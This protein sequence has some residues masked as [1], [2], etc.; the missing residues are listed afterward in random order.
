MSH[1]EKVGF[2][3]L[4]GG[5]MSS[6]VWTDITAKISLPLITPEY[7]LPENTEYARKMATISD[8]SDYIIGLIEESKFE[9]AILV[10]HSGAGVIAA[11]VAKIIPQRI[12]HIVYIA[13]S[14]PESGKSAVDSLPLPLRLLNKA[15]INSQVKR[16]FTPA[17]KSEKI[18]RKKFC[19]TCSEESIKYVLKQNLLSE[20]LCLAFEKSNWDG[21]PGVKQ[22]Y[23]ILTKDETISVSG[24]KKMMDHLSISSFLEIESGHMVML[25][26]PEELAK[27]LNSIIG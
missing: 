27:V 24:Q 18:I 15:A 5:G 19:N 6:W 23:I 12:L 4:A 8:C 16:D 14:I 11:N 2:V 1:N 22:T 10:A 17:K 3:F 13:A 21:F 25:S 7:R 26:H 9:K 20:P